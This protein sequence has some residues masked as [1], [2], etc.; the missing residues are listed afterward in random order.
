VT[1]PCYICGDNQSV[2]ANT[3]EPGSTLKKKS[4]SIAYQFVSEG[5]ANDEWRTS[6]VNTN[7]NETN[8]L[9]K[10]LPVGEKRRGFVRK[11]PPPHLQE[12]RCG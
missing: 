1:D 6:C 8:L 3:T 7:K 10:M 11:S 4:Q 2:L 5:V 9:T 12:L